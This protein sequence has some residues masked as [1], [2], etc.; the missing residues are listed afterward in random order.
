MG[1]KTRVQHLS[2]DVE[3]HRRLR[4]IGSE[5]RNATSKPASSTSPTS[6]S[7]DLGVVA[8]ETRASRSLRQVRDKL[9]R[10]PLNASVGYY[11]H[12]TMGNMGTG[13]RPLFNLES[14]HY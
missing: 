9:F 10:Q 3:L 2:R 8:G 7:R 14:L 6:D 13:Q 4:G 1:V 12:T 11:D 5:C